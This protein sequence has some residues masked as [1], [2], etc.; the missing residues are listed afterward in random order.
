MHQLQ[1]LGLLQRIITMG[2]LVPVGD[3]IARHRGHDVFRPDIGSDGSHSAER[4]HRSWNLDGLDILL[5]GLGG[6]NALRSSNPCRR[7]HDKRPGPRSRPNDRPP[8]CPAP[9]TV[10][11]RRGHEPGRWLYCFASATAGK[12]CGLRD[13]RIVR[14]TRRRR[15]ASPDPTGAACTALAS[16]TRAPA[17]SPEFSSCLARSLFSSAHIADPHSTESIATTAERFI[18]YT[19][20][21]IATLYHIDMRRRRAA[22]VLLH[23]S[24]PRDPINLCRTTFCRSRLMASTVPP[25]ISSSIPGIRC[26]AQSSHIPTQTTPA[27]DAEHI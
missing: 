8:A 17:A 19:P 7:L 1:I 4:P 11:P 20:L 27:R 16:T 3:H 18:A 5:G 24:S 22:L 21:Y 6:G 15:S 9:P 26:R 12:W 2:R 10:V 23:E 13:R 25:E 14:E